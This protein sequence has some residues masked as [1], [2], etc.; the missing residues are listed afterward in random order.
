MIAT[1]NDKLYIYIVELNDLRSRYKSVKEENE[2][3]NNSLNTLVKRIKNC[4]GPELVHILRHNLSVEEGGLSKLR[5]TDSLE[6]NKII[7]GQYSKDV[8]FDNVIFN[9]MKIVNAVRESNHEALELRLLSLEGFEAG[10]YKNSLYL[11][12]IDNEYDPYNNNLNLYYY[13]DIHEKGRLTDTEI[14]IVF[15]FSA[16]IIQG[17]V[18]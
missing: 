6:V 14:L 2:F 13:I 3:I 18:K 1:N 15:L 4:E 9:V 16:N 5:K 10:K 11:K 8:D 7:E 17:L 12:I